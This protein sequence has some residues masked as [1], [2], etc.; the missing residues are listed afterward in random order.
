MTDVESLV[1]RFDPLTNPGLDQVYLYLKKRGINQ[2]DMDALGIQLK[3][4]AQ[5]I[6]T[7][8]NKQPNPA[9][10]RVAA[11]FPHYDVLGRTIDWWSARLID[12]GLSAVKGWQAAVEH[13]WGKMFCPP[14]E[15]PRAYLVPSLDWTKLTRGARVYIHESCI[16]AINGAALGKWSIGLNGVWGWCSKKHD[17]ALVEELKSLPWKSLELQPVIVFDSNA[18]DNWDVQNA[19]TQLAARLYLVTGRQAVHILLPAGGDGHWGFDDFRMSVGDK[20]ATQFLDQDGVLVEVDEFQRMR[21]ELNA[22]C[23]VVSSLSCVADQDTGTLMKHSGFINVNYA[24]FI[25]D[26]EDEAVSVARAWLRWDRRTEVKE[27]RYE[28]GGE[29]IRSGEYLNLWKGMGVQAEEGDVRPWLELLERQ[30]PDRGLRE[31]VL[32]WFAYP[33]QNLGAKLSSFLHLYGPP[34]SGKNALLHPLMTIYGSNGIVINKDQIASTFNS[35]Y[36]FR[37]FVNLDEIHGGTDM[38]AMAITNRIKGM[39]T[40]PKLLVNRKGEPEYEIDNHVNLV[41][42]SNYSDSLKLDEGDRRACVIRFGGLDDAGWWGRYFQW[43][44]AFDSPEPGAGGA[45]YAFLL[46]VDLTGFDPAGR[47]YMTEWKEMV[48]DATRSP[49][50]KWVR[51]LWDDPDSVLPP[52]MRGRKVL[53]PEQVGAAYYPDDPGKN[54]PGLRNSLGQRMTDLGFKRMILKV[55]GA[56][57]RV[58]VLGRD[59]VSMDEARADLR[60]GPGGKY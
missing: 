38:N 46:G 17:V 40:S 41:T 16:K 53:T 35:V 56:T 22:R 30:I 32:K 2:E 51:D 18:S 34:G 49:M 15:P 57:K 27:L 44:G 19:I 12:S 24:H 47:A 1:P 50:E 8:I 20:L 21:M 23:C 42:T 6:A 37:Q 3:P 9:D 36:A 13:K 26:V 31:W 54:T 59:D 43:A 52:V 60:R 14:N 48:T 5:L 7:A 10:S 33:L 45:L 39:V 25:A 28:P 58:W 55:D 4:A 11:V 29:K